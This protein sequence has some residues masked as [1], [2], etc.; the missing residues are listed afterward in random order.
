MTAP[1]SGRSVRA[2]KR[3]LD[4]QAWPDEPRASLSG[5]VFIVVVIGNTRFCRRP[6]ESGCC[7]PAR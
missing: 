1:R 2:R 6:G 5:Q 7:H 4:P 3:G